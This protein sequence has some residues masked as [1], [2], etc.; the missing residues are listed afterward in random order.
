MNPPRVHHATT[1]PQFRG[2]RSPNTT[3][4]PDEV[5][6]ELLADLSGA[7]VKVLL[8]ICRRTFGWKKESDNISLNQMLHGITRKDGIT[9]DR[10]VGLSKPTL[11]RSIKS[12]CEKGVIVAEQRESR[13]KGFEATNYR[14]RMEHAPNPLGQIMNQGMSQNLTK[15]LVKKVDLQETKQQETVNKTV[16]GDGS[17][18]KTLPNLGQSRD[19]TLYVA[20]AILEQLGDQQ[21]AQ[22]YQ[23]IAAKVPEHVIYQALSQIKVDGA[24][25]PAKLFT[26]KMKLYAFSRVKNEIVHKG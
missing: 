4:I 3:P 7:E 24:R 23:L 16:N 19:K 8:Y 2:F 26:H 12:L 20:H 9:L 10:G 13:E 25:E 15:P 21:S 11:L 6:D 18:F 14:L 1:G 22:F 17:I 5:F